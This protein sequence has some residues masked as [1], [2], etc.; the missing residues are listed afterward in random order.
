MHLVEAAV[1]GQ[2]FAKYFV[3]DDFMCMG[4]L[5]RRG[6]PDL[7]LN[8]HS[9]TRRYLNL[10]ADGHAYRYLAPPEESESNGQYRP[11][12][13]LVSAIDA[14]HLHEMPWLTGSGF[15]DDQRG[16]TWEE[17]WE[18]PDVSAW[19]ARVFAREFG[20]RAATGRTRFRP[21]SG[22]G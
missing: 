17:R 18:Q 13:D 16:L 22:A 7:F 6:R 10:D 3:V 1:A 5:H 2:E 12:G 4:L 14:L 15:E 11:Y 8:K 21:R 9:L 19:L 20:R